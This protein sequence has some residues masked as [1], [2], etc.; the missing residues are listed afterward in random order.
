MPIEDVIAELQK[1]AKIQPGIKVMGIANVFDIE[2]PFAL[3]YIA[4]TEIIT[5]HQFRP[6]CNGRDGEKIVGL[7]LTV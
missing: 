6:C 2:A 5:E 1:L 7:F 3:D 4:L